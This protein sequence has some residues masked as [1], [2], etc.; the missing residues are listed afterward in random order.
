[1]DKNYY[2]V[3]VFAALTNPYLARIT[4]RRDGRRIRMP[5][6]HN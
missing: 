2:K 4:L 1:M 5:N 3:N 6:G